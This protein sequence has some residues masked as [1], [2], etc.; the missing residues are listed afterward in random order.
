MTRRPARARTA[1]RESK[2]RPFLVN[3][4][5]QS[6]GRTAGAGPQSV[7]AMRWKLRRVSPRTDPVR[8]GALC[9]PSGQSAGRNSVDFSP[10]GLFDKP[11][12]V[13]RGFEDMRR[14][15]AAGQRVAE[16]QAHALVV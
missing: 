1:A 4:W 11:V 5:T 16:L 3:P 14:D 13:G 2:S 6:T 15:V 9:R 10:I 8:S 12:G 7:N